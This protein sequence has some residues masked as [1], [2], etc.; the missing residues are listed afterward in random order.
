MKL[1]RYM[2]SALFGF[3]WCLLRSQRQPFL[4]SLGLKVLAPPRYC[5][6]CAHPSWE[7][8]EVFSPTYFSSIST[9]YHCNK[10]WSLTSRK[11]VPRGDTDR[12]GWPLAFQST[13][14]KT[15]LGLW[16][17]ERTELLGDVLRNGSAPFPP[18][19]QLIL[20]KVGGAVWSYLGLLLCGIACSLMGPHS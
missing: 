13:F 20:L 12:T 2:I 5:Q 18:P 8:R 4:S 7:R 17:S 15:G 11:V 9:H 19:S 1:S 10:S 3:A 6:A 16:Y 14:L